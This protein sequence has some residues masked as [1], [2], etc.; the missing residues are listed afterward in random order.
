M[1]PRLIVLCLTVTLLSGCGHVG[2]C[3]GWEPV[4]TSK[5]DTQ[6][7]RDAATK[8]NEYGEK[9]GCWSTKR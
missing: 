7:T 3:A 4:L 5:R 6:Q 2:N 1:G 9:Q 8:H